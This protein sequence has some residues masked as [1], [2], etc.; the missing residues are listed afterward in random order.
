MVHH[1][2]QSSAQMSDFSLAHLIETRLRYYRKNHG[3]PV[4]VAASLVYI[5]GCLRQLNRNRRKETVKLRAT[6]RWW[7]SLL[8]A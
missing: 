1:Q 7:R 5:A 6:L 8:T 2:G 3:L 4:A